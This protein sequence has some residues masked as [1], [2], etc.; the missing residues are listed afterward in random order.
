VSRVP[1]VGR[2]QRPRPPSFATSETRFPPRLPTEILARAP[3]ALPSPSAPPPLPSL[4]ADRHAI[5]HPPP[6]IPSP[7]FGTPSSFTLPTV[8]PHRRTSS[9]SSFR[10]LS[11]TRTTPGP[12]PH[13]S[14]THRPRPPPP[15]ASRPSASNPT[16]FPPGFQTDY[17]R[18]SS[19]GCRR[20]N[21]YTE[22]GRRGV[23][24]GDVRAAPGEAYLILRLHRRPRGGWGEVASN[25]EDPSSW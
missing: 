14:H 1:V 25:S 12:Q 13:S 3:T 10:A 21:R 5:I 16:A 18:A 20:P 9:S 24:F 23:A 2:M 4:S 17:V 15:P 6:L 22:E 11:Q 7:Y 19:P 8:Y